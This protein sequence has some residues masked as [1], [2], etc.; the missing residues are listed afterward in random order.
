MIRKILNYII[1]ALKWYIEVDKTGVD[2][3]LIWFA[4]MF[5]ITLTI[6]ENDLKENDQIG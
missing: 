2:A 1:K 5:L 3:I 6:K 4:L